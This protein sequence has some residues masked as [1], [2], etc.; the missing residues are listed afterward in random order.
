MINEWPIPFGKSNTCDGNHRRGR[1]MRMKTVRQMYFVGLGFVKPMM[2]FSFVGKAF[3]ALSGETWRAVNQSLARH[4]KKRVWFS[5][6]SRN[7]RKRYS[8]AK[9]GILDA[10]QQ[11]DIGLDVKITSRHAPET[12]IR[13]RVAVRFTIHNP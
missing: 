12:A 6:E 5:G 1:A 13:R 7:V 2:E 8:M 9:W 11:H 4:A 3:S 10:H